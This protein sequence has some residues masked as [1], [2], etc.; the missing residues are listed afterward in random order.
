MFLQCGIWRGSGWAFDQKAFLAVRE[1]KF[2]NL[3]RVQQDSE[4]LKPQSLLRNCV[5]DTV[6]MSYN[7]GYCMY[8]CACFGCPYV[9]ST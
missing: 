2:C 1:S 6:F 7:G 3:R 9:I 8:L 4:L 5:S